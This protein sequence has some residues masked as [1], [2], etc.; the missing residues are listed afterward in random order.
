MALCK[1]SQFFLDS[2]DLVV[3]PVFLKRSKHIV[4]IFYRVR[5][6]ADLDGEYETSRLS[7]C[8]LKTRLRI[9]VH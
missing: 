3:N 2:L 1:P 9:V 7:M 6:H 5:A 8:G 4:I